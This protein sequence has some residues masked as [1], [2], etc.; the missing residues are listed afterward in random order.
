MIRKTFFLYLILF[1]FWYLKVKC[2]QPYFPPQITFLREDAS[3]SYLYAI[4][5]INQR[6]YRWNRIDPD[7]QF[8]SFVMQHF[9]YATPKSP[10]SKNYVQLDI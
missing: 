8:Y 7:D 4:D 5:E 6:A 1:N 9:P 3:N 10:E 2:S